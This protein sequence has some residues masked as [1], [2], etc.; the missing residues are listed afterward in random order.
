MVR[1]VV[2]SMMRGGETLRGGEASRN[3]HTIEDTADAVG[4]AV[5]SGH[6]VLPVLWPGLIVHVELDQRAPQAIVSHDAY[7]DRLQL[8]QLSVWQRKVEADGKVV[9]DRL[10]LCMHVLLDL[11]VRAKPRMQ[12]CQHVADILEDR[13]KLCLELPQPPSHLKPTPCEGQ[14]LSGGQ[15]CTA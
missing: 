14:A 11:S 6:G 1:G 3:L 15:F 12:A 10:W 8:P 5:I 9:E 13:R 4:G 7:R 2:S